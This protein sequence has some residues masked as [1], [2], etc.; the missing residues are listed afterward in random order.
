MVAASFKS[1]HFPEAK[2]SNKIVRFSNWDFPLEDTRFIHINS[3]VSDCRMSSNG[4]ATITITQSFPHFL[5][6][7][8]LRTDCHYLDTFLALIHAAFPASFP[9]NS[10]SNSY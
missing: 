2:D 6:S 10:V 4:I 1:L 3:S 9:I 7:Y 5:P 8:S